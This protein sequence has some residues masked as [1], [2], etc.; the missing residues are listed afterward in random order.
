[1]KV[2]TY[3]EQETKTFGK[4][5]GTYIKNSGI[6]VI[7]LYG[8]M[9]AG[10]TVLTKGIASA[11]GIEEKDIASSSFVIASQYP[12]VDFYHIDLYRVDNIKEEEL[13]LWEYFEHGTCVVEWAERLNDLPEKTLKITINLVDEKIRVL[14]MEL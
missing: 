7:A 2:F 9:G 1:M 13:D 4:M 8:E 6:N 14:E 10:K 3:S 11:F 5:I 12:E